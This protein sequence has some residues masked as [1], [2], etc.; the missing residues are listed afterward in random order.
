MGVS[1]QAPWEGYIKHCSGTRKYF[2]IGLNFLKVL[3]VLK[4][5]QIL[6]FYQVLK[7]Y[8]VCIEVLSGY[9]SYQSIWP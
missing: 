3:K 6:K 9:Q 4:V 5:Y 1:P 8:Q 7:I 2:L